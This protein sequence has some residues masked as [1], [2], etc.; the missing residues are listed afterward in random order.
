MNA[1]LETP[2]LNASLEDLQRFYQVVRSQV[3]HEPHGEPT[4]TGKTVDDLVARAARFASEGTILN[5]VASV[6]VLEQGG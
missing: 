1:P 2:L 6:K 3:G 5:V 4:N